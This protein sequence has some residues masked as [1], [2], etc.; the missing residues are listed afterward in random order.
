[1]EWVGGHVFHITGY[2]HSWR[3]GSENDIS[4][5]DHDGLD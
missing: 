3:F 5:S 1:M 4:G 2:S